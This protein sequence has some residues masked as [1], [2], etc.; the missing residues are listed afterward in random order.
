MTWKPVM[1]LFWQY[2]NNEV[3]EGEQVGF[4]LVDNK[5]NKTPLHAT[6]TELFAAQ[7]EAAKEM[8][9]R[10]R[11]LPGYEEIATFSET[12]LTARAPR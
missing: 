5:N 9:G 8:R 12:W 1:T 3:V 10:T 2:Y 7:E 6:L 11:R 4:W